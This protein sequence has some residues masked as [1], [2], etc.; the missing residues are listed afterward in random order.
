MASVFLDWPSCRSRLAMVIRAR[1]LALAA[2]TC[3]VAAEEMAGGLDPIALAKK[4][5]STWKETTYG[6]HID[7]PGGTGDQMLAQGNMVDYT[8]YMTDPLYKAP[9]QYW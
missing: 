9:D 1:L 5:Y 2:V 6:K 4:A 3:A 8:Q 7:L